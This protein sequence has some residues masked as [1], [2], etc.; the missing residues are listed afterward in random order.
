VTGVFLVCEVEPKVD[1][2]NYFSYV[3]FM[4]FH[5]SCHLYM[6][7]YTYFP[8]KELWKKH[9]SCIIVKGNQTLGAID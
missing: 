9:K 8:I 1:C 7:A 5:N 2:S 6:D 3:L 4:I